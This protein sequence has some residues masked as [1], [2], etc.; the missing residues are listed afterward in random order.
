MIDGRNDGQQRRQEAGLGPYYATPK[1]GPEEIRRDRLLSNAARLS[2][3]GAFRSYVFR[4]YLTNNFPLCTFCG[5]EVTAEHALFL[6]PK[7]DQ[8]TGEVPQSG[9]NEH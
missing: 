6:V 2:G 4:F 5:V 1:I 8:E 3:N 7:V 9:G